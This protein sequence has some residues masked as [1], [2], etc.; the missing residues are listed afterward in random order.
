MDQRENGSFRLLTLLRFACVVSRARGNVV[1]EQP[2][3]MMM[4]PEYGV[5]NTQIL[6][7]EI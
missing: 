5:T 3:E 2:R 1:I 7:T 6:R 4:T